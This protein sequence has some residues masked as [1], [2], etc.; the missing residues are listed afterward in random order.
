MDAEVV[1][2][3]VEVFGFATHDFTMGFA[4]L[5]QAVQK[6]QLRV[7]HLRNGFASRQ[8]GRGVFQPSFSHH[9]VKHVVAQ[10]RGD[11][12]AF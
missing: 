6:C 10:V 1:V 8:F 11:K 12:N 3:A 4:V 2:W 5:G 9:I 7:G